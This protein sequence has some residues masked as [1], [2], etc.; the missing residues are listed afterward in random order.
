MTY[1]G[2]LAVTLSH[3]LPTT[4][5]DLMEAEHISPHFRPLLS[6][7][8]MARNGKADPKQIPEVPPEPV[9]RLSLEASALCHTLQRA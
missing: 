1:S 9:D 5:E 4:Y 6:G 3:V 8:C 7:G 2:R